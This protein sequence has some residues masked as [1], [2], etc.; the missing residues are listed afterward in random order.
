MISGMGADELLTRLRG[1]EPPVIARV[2]HGRVMLDMRTV[3]P[4]E[5]S[6]IVAALKSALGEI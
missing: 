6:E 2:E 5:E 4:G 3:L 1:H